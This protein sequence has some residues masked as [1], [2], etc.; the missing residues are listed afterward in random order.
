[1]EVRMSL[2]GRRHGYLLFAEFND[3][4]QPFAARPG[5]MEAS[6]SRHQK[7]FQMFRSWLGLEPPPSADPGGAVFQFQVFWDGYDR[8]S[9]EDEAAAAELFARSATLVRESCARK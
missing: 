5:G 9:T 7:S 1:M 4:G 8:L 3:C 2:P 6:F